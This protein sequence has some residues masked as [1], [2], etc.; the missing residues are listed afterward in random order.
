MAV[1]GLI[2]SIIAVITVLYR[3]VQGGRTPQLRALGIGVVFSFAASLVRIPGVSAL[4]VV[5]GVDLTW[6]VENIVGMLCNYFMLC[7]MYFTVEEPA[8]A[9][10]QTRR[11]LTALLCAGA[12]LVFLFS[13]APHSREFDF[14]PH[15]R[16]TAG[17]RPD[18]VVGP[19]AWL[20]LAVYLV[21]PLQD[22]ARVSLR[23]ARKAAS[24]RWLSL[25]LGT[26]S[27]CVSIAAIVQFHVIAYQVA[28]LV[29]GLAPFP[30]PEASVEGPPLAVAGFGSL[31]GLCATGVYSVL[32][33]SPWLRPVREMLHRIQ[34]WW[35]CYA[36]CCRLYALWSTLW[37]A[38]PSVALSPARSRAADLLRLRATWNLHRRIIELND[39]LQAFR[40]HVDADVGDLAETLAR[41]RGLT[42]GDAAALVD[43][44]VLAVGREAYLAGRPMP[45]SVVDVVGRRSEV[46]GLAHEARHWLRVSALFFGSPIVAEASAVD[47]QVRRRGRG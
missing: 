47:A 3:V 5:G 17:G 27:L 41:E 11:H 2:G 22:L 14:G 42:G 21:Y 35:Q 33:T 31:V 36:V 18:V 12:I 43:A 28:L 38:L 15:G 23:W 45:G 34:L 9:A 26:Y 32:M 25:A 37:R 24:V 30:W 4:L 44:V 6:P 40:R 39:F 8:A 10:R 13:L 29:P 7:C 20:I 16:Y 19:I 46:G 1:V